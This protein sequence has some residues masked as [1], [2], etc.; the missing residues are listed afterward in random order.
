M[1]IK[2]DVLCPKCGKKVATYDG[3]S[4]MNV[5]TRCTKCRKR[6]IFHVDTKQTTI[7]NIPPSNTSSGK[8]LS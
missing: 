8:M 3:R 5:L 6:V 7:S 4:T 1:Y 2:R